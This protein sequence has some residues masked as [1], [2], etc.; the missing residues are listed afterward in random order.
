MDKKDKEQSD[1]DSDL[2]KTLYQEYWTDL[3]EFKPTNRMLQ[4]NGAMTSRG[5]K[6]AIRG[7]SI[8]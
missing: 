8:E 1:Y 5:N 4:K 7:S 6:S 3:K 2:N